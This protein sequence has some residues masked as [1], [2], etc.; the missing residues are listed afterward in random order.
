MVLFRRNSSSCTTE[1]RYCARVSTSSAAPAVTAAARADARRLL[2]ASTAGRAAPDDVDLA[3]LPSPWLY[4]AATLHRIAPALRRS[5]NAATDVPVRLRQALLHSTQQ[6]RIGHLRSLT[7]LA[8]IGSVFEGEG[9][10][11]AVAKG[12]VAAAH[13]WPAADMRQYTDVDVYVAPADFQRALDALLA[14]GCTAVDRNWPEIARQR[15]AELA[16]RGRHGSMIDLH[17]HIAVRPELRSAFTIDIDGMFERVRTVRLGNASV[18][19]FGREDGALLL[20]FHAA[21][22]GG[23]RLMWLGDLWYAT[24]ESSFSW[25]LLQERARAASVT[26]PVALVCARMD[27]L[28]GADD[29]SSPLLRPRGAW[30]WVARMSARR[31]GAVFLEGDRHADGGVVAAARPSLAATVRTA[32][33]DRWSIRRGERDW[34][35]G[36]QAANPLDEDVPDASAREYYLRQVVRADRGGETG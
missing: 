30:A 33:R 28:L 2:V 22:S 23:N 15:R 13:L 32:V 20:A 16:L 18:P 7:D 25:G 19:T 9:V 26:L 14:A 17:W 6:Q 8:H 11:W 4:R 3:E 34:D 12:P 35:R 10:R 27:A 24:R 31:S 29:Q 1:K 21:M 36:H 5:L